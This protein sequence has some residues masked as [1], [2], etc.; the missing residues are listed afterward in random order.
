MEPMTLILTALAQGAA[1][2]AEK[3]AGQAI[4]DGYAGLKSLIKRKLGNAPEKVTALEQHESA[5]EVWEKPLEHALGTSE[6]DKDSEIL[7]LARKLLGEINPEAA[8]AG[9]YNV[10]ITNGGKVEGFIQHASGDVTF[11]FGKSD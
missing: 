10:N 11:N 6:V 9:T 2:V 3:T 8:A 1:T 5:P 4:K 7:E